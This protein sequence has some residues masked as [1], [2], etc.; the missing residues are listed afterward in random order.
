MFIEPCGCEHTAA[1]FI[2]VNEM[3]TLKTTP[4]LSF[5]LSGTAHISCETDVTPIEVPESAHNGEQFH[6]SAVSPSL[7]KKGVLIEKIALQVNTTQNNNKNNPTSKTYKKWDS[8]QYFYLIREWQLT[9]DYKLAAAVL[10]MPVKTAANIISKFKSAGK[11]FPNPRG[12]SHRKYDKKKISKFLAQYLEFHS[13]STLEEMKEN[14]WENRDVLLEPSCTAPSIS[15]IC[16][17]LKQSLFDS[18]PITLKIASI[19]PMKRNSEETLQSRKQFVQWYNS[20]SDID[21]KRLVWV[22]EHGF[23]FY[24]VKHRAWSRQGTPAVVRTPTAKGNLL[25]VILAVSGTFGKIFMEVC[26]E[27]SCN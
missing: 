11:T 5:K 22:D 17:L 14:I 23:N 4:H 13:N 16:N 26:C 6:L 8:S 19:D 24:T 25:S 15:W 18:K 7:Y 10:G 1:S 2:C 9:G 12:N 27:T 3:T 21:V 20:L